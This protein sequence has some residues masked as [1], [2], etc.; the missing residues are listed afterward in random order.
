MHFQIR[1]IDEGSVDWLPEH[2]RE[3]GWWQGHDGGWPSPEA[4]SAWRGAAGDIFGYWGK[5]ATGDDDLLG[6][7]QLGPSELYSRARKIGGSDLK[8]SILL[9]CSFITAAGFG[10]IRKSLV[11]TVLAELREQGVEQVDTFCSNEDDLTDDCRLFS[12]SFTDECGFYPVRST[13]DFTL[14]RLELSGA[15]PTRRHR[16]KTGSRLLERFKRSSAAPS[17]AAMCQRRPSA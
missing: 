9:T 3:C 7:I 13:G 17:P 15:E 12:R 14:M 10:S 1:N 6:F 4:A 16:Q 2:C 8:D 11:M 5:M